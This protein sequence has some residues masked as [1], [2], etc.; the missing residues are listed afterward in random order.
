MLDQ[1]FNEAARRPL[2]FAAALLHRWG[3]SADGLTLAGFFL[4]ML[5]LPLLAM[6]HPLWALAA[7]ALNRLADGLDGALA[8]LGT[9]TDR[10]AYLDIVCDFLFYASVPFGFAMANPTDNALPAATLLFAFMG[11]ASS[12][13]AFGVLAAKRGITNL[14]YPQKGFYYLGGLTESTETMAA[15]ALMCLN[16]SWFASLAYGFSALCALTTVTRLVAGWNA[17][18]PQ[19][20]DDT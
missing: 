8:R 20:P 7:M 14:A 16:P 1:A 3:I 9:P 6:G 13:L 2:Q 10:G 11:T 5:C 15:F 18:K 12:F 4:G 19:E 17:F